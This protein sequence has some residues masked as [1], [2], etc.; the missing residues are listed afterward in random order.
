MKI[1]PKCA[2]DGPRGGHFTRSTEA[3]R[4]DGFRACRPSGGGERSR[5]FEI[6]PRFEEGCSIFAARACRALFS[7][8]GALA[9]IGSA[10]KRWDNPVLIE[11]ARQPRAKLSTARACTLDLRSYV[12]D[13][14]LPPKEPRGV[15]R[16]DGLSKACPTH[17][18]IRSRDTLGIPSRVSRRSSPH[19]TGC[20]NW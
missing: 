13:A 18:Q 2:S 8:N 5:N 15:A 14:G 7:P 9:T 19:I 17:G 1:R 16:S 4:Y 20:F 6:R 11:L 12:G 3:R 10:G